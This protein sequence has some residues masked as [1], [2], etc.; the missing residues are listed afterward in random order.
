VI[1]KDKC[2]TLERKKVR[3]KDLGLGLFVDNMGEACVENDRGR[4]VGNVHSTRFTDNQV[5]G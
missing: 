4:D 5:D 1:S 2:S 3:S